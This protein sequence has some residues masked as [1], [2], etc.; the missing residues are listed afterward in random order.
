MDY[1]LSSTLGA[2]TLGGSRDSGTTSQGSFHWLLVQAEQRH[3]EEVARLRSENERCHKELHRLRTSGVGSALSTPASQHPPQAPSPRAPVVDFMPPTYVE[4]IED[5]VLSVQDGGSTP[6]SLSLPPPKV[7][8]QV[9]LQPV[10]NAT[11][12]DAKTR[13]VQANSETRESHR[14]PLLNLEKIQDKHRMQLRARLC[15][16]LEIDFHS[17]DKKSIGFEHLWH[18]VMKRLT[19]LNWSR[20]HLKDVL[21]ELH[22]IWSRNPEPSPDTTPDL[23]RRQE[24]DEISKSGESRAGSK[25]QSRHGTMPMQ[26][27]GTMHSRVAH[28]SIP[29]ETLMFVLSTKDLADLADP[30]HAMDV[31]RFQQA[32]LEETEMASLM[33]VF[34]GE[35]GEGQLG[36]EAKTSSLTEG[37]RFDRDCMLLVLN[38][39]VSVALVLSLVILAVS[40]DISPH[41]HGWL[42]CETV[43]TAIFFFEMAVKV[44]IWGRYEYFYGEERRWNWLDATIN[45]L[46]LI[47]LVFSYIFLGQQDNDGVNAVRVAVMFRILRVARLVRL[48]KLLKHP[49]LRDLANLLAGLLIGMPWLFWVLVLLFL[50]LYSMG[51]C[52]RLM[53]GPTSGDEALMPRCGSGDAALISNPQ[54]PDCDR[55]HYL[56]GEEF[57]GDVTT[58]MFTTFRCLIGD[59]TTRT[60]QSLTAHFAH[61]YGI[62]FYIVYGVGMICIIFGLFNVITALFVESTLSGLKYNDVQKKYARMYESRYVY[63]KMS[64]LIGRIRHLHPTGEEDMTH[65]TVT[66]ADF[67]QMI[68]DPNL[69]GLLDDL[70]VATMGRADFFEIIDFDRDGVIALPDLV[71]GLMKLRGETQKSDIMANWVAIRTLHDRFVDFERTAVE[72]HHHLTDLIS[73]QQRSIS[74]TLKGA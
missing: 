65:L 25:V 70:D 14:N 39:M 60:G 20:E 3:N 57:F 48:V 67:Q 30:D 5:E 44:S 58:S 2:S 47:D 7:K 35:H 73:Q 71:A 19:H 8:K 66:R 62:R 1:G 51:I 52:L 13:V 42:V 9:W 29:F 16:V 59:C 4:P 45:A 12:G 54:D 74:G 6:L 23:F 68:K 64:L 24:S 53:L 22:C 28:L 21:S 11:R 15:T 63:H 55:I 69:N 27:M 36:A 49:I 33:M 38:S 40:S 61:G 17:A 10:E 26:K 18:V 41:W 31:E 46:A 50:I 72:L 37:L 34:L 43:L 56:Y 32:L